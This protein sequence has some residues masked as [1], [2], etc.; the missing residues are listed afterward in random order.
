MQ[1]HRGACQLLRSRHTKGGPHLAEFGVNT[2]ANGNAQ[3]SAALASYGTSA[4]SPRGGRQ[5]AGSASSAAIALLRKP[6]VSVALGLGVS[7]AALGRSPRSGPPGLEPGLL[8]LTPGWQQVT[9]ARRPAAQLRPSARHPWRLHIVGGR[10]TR[11]TAEAVP[12]AAKQFL[13][14]SCAAVAIPRKNS[15]A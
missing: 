13:T 2:V 4:R 11:M 6:A 15:H 8:C 14:T 3:G 9:V 10:S 7:A 1:E 5:A 12:S